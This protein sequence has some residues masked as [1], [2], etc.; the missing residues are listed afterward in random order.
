MVKTATEPSL[1]V[2]PVIS[3]SHTQ[4]L[5]PECLAILEAEVYEQAGKVWIRKACAKHG[6]FN[7][8]YWGSS[9]LYRRAKRYARDGKGVENHFVT[10]QN[11]VCP[12]DCGLCN[13][14]MSHTA[15]G[16][17]ALTNRCDLNC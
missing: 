15:L 7:E 13:L 1:R 5:C 2:E 4:S 8:L 6:E 14:H 12:V 11:P 10:K 9:D 16:N 17:I 3:I